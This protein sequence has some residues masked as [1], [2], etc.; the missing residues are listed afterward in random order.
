MLLLRFSRLLQLATRALHPSLDISSMVIGGRDEWKLEPKAVIKRALSIDGCKHI[1]PTKDDAI[2]TSPLLSFL[3]GMD[4]RDVE[5]LAR[6]YVFCDTGT[7]AICRI[8]LGEVRKTFRKHVSSLDAVE[9]ILREP[10]ALTTIDDSLVALNK[11]NDTSLKAELE[12]ADVG[13]A[14]LQGEREKLVHHLESIAEVAARTPANPD[15]SESE[16]SLQG[17]EFQFSLPPQPMK[18]VDQCLREIN[19]MGKIVRSVATNGKGTVFLYGN[20]GVAYTPNIP[21]PLYHK[22]SQLRSS[23]LTHRPSYVALG[24]R[25]RYFCA[26]HDGSFT[27]KGPKGLDRDLKKIRKPP[28]S[29]AFGS[30]FD[31]Y[32]LV[33]HDG[34]WKYQ[35][36][37]IP[38]ELEDKLIARQE[39]DDLVCV[40]LGPQGEWFLRASNGRMWWGNV[41]GELDAALSELLDQGHYLNR[42]DFGD[43]GSY[44]IS[45]D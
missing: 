1:A 36:R 40:N 29:V 7:V 11:T 44:F 27:F 31:T 16:L 30:S 5:Q 32:F 23:S 28:L 45:Y 26:F 20:G 24:T 8:L 21:R 12:L 10:P 41:S 33:F 39:R 42:I 17:L 35:G 3:V 15:V 2:E 43:D 38:V 6:I 4:R 25:D 34:S 13:I 18:H 9:R 14:I 22:L 37:G 19:A